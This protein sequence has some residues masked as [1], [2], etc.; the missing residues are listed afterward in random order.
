MES[1]Y[2]YIY[3]YSFDYSKS[4]K[5][6]TKSTQPTEPAIQKKSCNRRDK[7]SCPLNGECLTLNVVY[8]ETVASEKSHETYIGLTGD[9]FKN[10]YRNHTSS[11]RDKNKRN[12][13]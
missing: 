4:T 7:P 2:I 1:P 11:F 13:T 9:N 6:K 3:I 10:R 5:S 12:A 8:Q